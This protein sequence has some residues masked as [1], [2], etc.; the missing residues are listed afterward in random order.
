MKMNE[1]FEEKPSNTECKNLFDDALKTQSKKQL[2]K[3]S[4]SLFV[5]LCL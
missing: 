4:P 1:I 3:K 5:M 2:V